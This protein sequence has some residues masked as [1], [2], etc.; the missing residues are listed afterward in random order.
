[1]TCFLIAYL[2]HLRKVN[3]AALIVYEADTHVSLSTVKHVV[4]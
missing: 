2:K 4:Y 1:M 3:A